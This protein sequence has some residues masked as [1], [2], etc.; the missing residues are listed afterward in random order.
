MWI[1]NSI[2]KPLRKGNYKTFLH[3]AKVLTISEDG[4]IQQTICVHTDVTYL[5]IPFDH[6][7]SFIPIDCDLQTYHFEYLDNKYELASSISVKFT[8]RENDIITLLG[9]G[10]SVDKIA[11]ILF[12]S[13]HTVNTHKKNIFKKSQCRNSAELVVKCLREGFG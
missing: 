5:R 6:K 4:K 8:K 2:V 13:K 9:Q 1:N 10:K 12:I 7:I 3:Q 11:N